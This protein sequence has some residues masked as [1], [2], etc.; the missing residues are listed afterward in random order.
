M[1]RFDENASI[2]ICTKPEPSFTIFERPE[3]IHDGGTLSI[4]LFTLRLPVEYLTEF[5]IFSKKITS[6]LLK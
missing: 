1:R 6:A 3:C 5:H 4:A 2:V